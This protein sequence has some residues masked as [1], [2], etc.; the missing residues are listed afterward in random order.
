MRNRLGTGPSQL[1]HD[2]NTIITSK[3]AYGNSRNAAVF[4]QNADFACIAA[5]QVV[6]CGFMK[7]MNRGILGSEH[8]DRPASASALPPRDFLARA[9]RIGVPENFF[10]GLPDAILPPPRNLLLFFQHRVP[11]P[12]IRAAHHRHLLILNLV[13]DVRILIDSHMLCLSAGQALLLL[14]FPIGFHI[15]PRV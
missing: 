15:Q 10:V 14:R 6:A 9:R 7:P 12:E 5:R 3:H 8:R 4:A 13:S 2:I 1:Q 11:D